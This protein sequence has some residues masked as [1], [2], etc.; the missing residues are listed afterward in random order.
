MSFTGV[1][2][3]YYSSRLA[4][5]INYQPQNKAP[6]CKRLIFFLMPKL[7]VQFLNLT[8]ASRLMRCLIK[9][10]ANNLFRIQA[11]FPLLFFLP[12]LHLNKIFFYI[13]SYT[14]FLD[15]VSSYVRFSSFSL[16]LSFFSFFSLLSILHFLCFSPLFPLTSSS[17]YCIY[18]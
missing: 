8:D 2:S 11:F 10:S 12:F 7:T 4:V 16:F 17:L 9:S 15:S 13:I 6:L 14:F 18:F 5:R 1:K 3:F